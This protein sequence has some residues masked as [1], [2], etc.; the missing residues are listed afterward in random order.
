MKICSTPLHE[1][2]SALRSPKSSTVLSFDLSRWDIV[3][4]GNDCLDILILTY[5][6]ML[7]MCK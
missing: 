6:M 7:E 3:V 4:D 2:S 5:T 1:D